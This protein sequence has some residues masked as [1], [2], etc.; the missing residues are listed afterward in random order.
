MN[1]ETSPDDVKV[2]GLFFYPVKSCG[3]ISIA[4]AT[5]ETTG[6]AHDR[7]WMLVDTRHNPARFL[8]QREHPELATVGL[9]L[10]LATGELTL[11]RAGA[12]PLTVARPTDRSKLLR[13]KVWSAEVF[14]IDAGDAAAQWFAALL[15][16][17]AAQVRLVYFH[18]E[19]PRF[20]NTKYAGDV[21][22]T[23]YFAD[24]YPVLVTNQASLDDLNR[25]A[26]RSA[27]RALPMNR[28]RPNVVL[29][30]LPAWDEDHIDTLTVGSSLLKLV[31]PCVRCEITTTDQA[32]G[33]RL[34]DEPL[35]TLA[36]FRN[37]PDLGGVTFG[38]NAIVLNAGELAVN[39]PASVE[40]RF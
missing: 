36:R 6:L 24:G 35:N 29:S 28:F 18:R 9:T 13:V 4:K 22:A 3:G 23:T 26:N 20:C 16:G 11:S 2:S 7:E 12:A 14:G 37:N 31:K 34:S 1:S 27:E 21:G 17:S 39:Q 19:Y 25:R 10:H 38:W 5:L 15:G 32:T 30:G 33:S 40:Y 8:T